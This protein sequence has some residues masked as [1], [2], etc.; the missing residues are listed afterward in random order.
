MKNMK[1]LWKVMNMKKKKVKKEVKKKYLKN[2]L[3]NSKENLKKI[4]KYYDYSFELFKFVSY[5][6]QG[7]L[8]SYIERG[9]LS[10]IDL[11]KVYGSFGCIFDEDFIEWL[12]YYKDKFNYNN[13]CRP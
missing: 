9:Y 2:Y 4:Q 12:E 13:F 10:G 7:D 3:N 1:N 8:H 6:Y 11:E 5:I